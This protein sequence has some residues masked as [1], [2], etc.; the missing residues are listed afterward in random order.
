MT[1]GVVSKVPTLYFNSFLSLTLLLLLS[2]SLSYS[3]S[4]TRVAYY[5]VLKFVVYPVTAA[6]VSENDQFT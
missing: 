1:E 6:V 3:I 5:N 4:R 2:L